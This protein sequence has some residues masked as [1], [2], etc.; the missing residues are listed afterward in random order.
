[1]RSELNE[2]GHGTKV[3]KEKVWDRLV[4]IWLKLSEWK[5][6]FDVNPCNRASLI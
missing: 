1:M 4:D 3:I 5:K 6:K 2:F